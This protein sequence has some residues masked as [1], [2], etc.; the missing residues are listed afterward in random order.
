MI[1]NFMSW[2]FVFQIFIEVRHISTKNRTKKGE[3]V[4]E[5]E[6]T[7]VCHLSNIVYPSICVTCTT[8]ALEILVLLPS[9][10][11]YS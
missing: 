7:Y 3:I 9:L 11:K 1:P 5:I 6:D 8:L 4:L 10:L 2:I